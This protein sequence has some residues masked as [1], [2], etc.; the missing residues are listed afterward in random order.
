MSAIK[1]GPL[2][3]HDF[4]SPEP[5]PRSAKQR[6]KSLL[7]SGR[8]FRYQ[9]VE[10]V[11]TLEQQFSKYIGS[12][13]AVACNSGGCS[14]FLALL[15]L[16]V[17]PGDSVLTCSH[18]LAPVPGAIV[19]AGAKPIFVDTDPNTLSID[20]DDLE[21]KANASKSNVVVVS[22]MRGR[23]PDIDRMLSIADRCGL[24][25][26]EDCAHT[27]GATW[28]SATTTSNVPK[29]IGL[30]G[31]IGCWSLQTNKCINA[32][33]G[34]LLSTDREDLAAYLTVATGS[35]GH[36]S[37]NGASPPD[38]FV[39]K[40][41]PSIPNFSMRLNTIAAAIAL[42]QLGQAITNKV[43][44]WDRNMRILRSVLDSCQ[45]TRII[46]TD[47]RY[48]PAWSSVQFDLVG[49]DADMIKEYLKRAHEQGIPLA[50]FGGAWKGF[51]ST[52][53]DWKFA[54][55]TGD[56]WRSSTQEQVVSTLIDVPLYHTTRWKDDVIVHLGK[57]LV[58]IGESVFAGAA[59][60]AARTAASKL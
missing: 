55:E 51:T 43:K 34:G 39:E 40:L 57:T 58:S 49:F 2:T 10:D 3:P 6:V 45:H 29:H 12:R 60:G 22:Y 42:P 18:T 52:L 53:K 56:Q 25:I 23:V 16:G 9:Q 21:R 44:A 24:A 37:L 31:S 54:D 20:L 28:T 8:L 30:F 13:F 47:P 19:H 46:G 4:S 1:F 33:E 35:Y 15:A 50:W 11:A 17:K 59:A 36:F 48:A 27:L 7:E 38:V 32:G 41:Y 5:L 14:I 26:V